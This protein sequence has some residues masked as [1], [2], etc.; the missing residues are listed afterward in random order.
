MPRTTSEIIDQAIRENKSWERLVSAFA[1]LFVL[2]G[3]SMI[4]YSMVT[5]APITAVAGVAESSL[6]WPALNV[7]MRTRS[8]NIMLRMLEVP[9]NKAQTSQE[10]AEMLRRVFETSFVEVSAGKQQAAGAKK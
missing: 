3:L 7:A 1:A 2:V 10:A 6:F 4:V 8:A 9:L 5:K